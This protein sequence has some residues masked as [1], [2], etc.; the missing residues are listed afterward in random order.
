M[1]GCIQPMSSPMMKRM[2]GFV[3]WAEA[4]ALAMVVAVHKTRRAPQIT[5]NML[6]VASLDVGCRNPGRSLRPTPPTDLVS[7]FF[8][9][10]G[11]CFG[12][13][14]GALRAERWPK[15]FGCAMRIRQL[16]DM[17][18]GRVAAWSKAIH[19]RWHD[20]SLRSAQ[21]PGIGGFERSQLRSLLKD[22][23]SGAP[24]GP[25]SAV[26]ARHSAWGLR[27]GIQRNTSVGFA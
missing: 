2:L 8:A 25:C 14:S 11:S 16:S 26:G 9:H 15:C 24:S 13:R 19:R 1:P 18:A 4:G 7:A 21:A 27:R 20:M 5:L 23:H 3:P 12:L 6:M 22:R 17:F 10:T